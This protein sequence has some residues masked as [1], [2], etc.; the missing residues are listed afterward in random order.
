M[1]RRT[2]GEIRRQSARGNFRGR[3]PAIK[4]LS[5]ATN[6]QIASFERRNGL[7]PGYVA[8]AFHIWAQGLTPHP[9]GGL[10]CGAG[11]TNWRDMHARTLLNDILHTLTDRTSCGGAPRVPVA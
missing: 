10:A 2:P 8:R 11:T 6:H 5:G 3:A 1:P 7:P 9:N 4:G